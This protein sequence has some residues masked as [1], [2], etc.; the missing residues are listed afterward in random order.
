[1]GNGRYLHFAAPKLPSPFYAITTCGCV[2]PLNCRFT[3]FHNSLLTLLMT[4][5]MTFRGAIQD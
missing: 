2:G 1:M 3:V 4:L 5:R